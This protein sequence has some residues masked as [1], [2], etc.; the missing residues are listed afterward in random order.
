LRFCV[1]WG[2][3]KTKVEKRSEASNS[4]CPNDAHN[5]YSGDFGEESE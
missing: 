4:T 3:R 2:V 5:G 1:Q